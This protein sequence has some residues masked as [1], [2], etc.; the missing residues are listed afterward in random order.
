MRTNPWLTFCLAVAGLGAAVTPA[1]AQQ[2]LS[3]VLSVLLTNQAVPTG[4]FD[5][6]AAAAAAT[7]DTMERMLLVELTTLPLGSSSAGFSYRFNPTLGTLERATESFGPFFT[8]RALTAGSGRVALGATMQFARYT[9]L[10]GFDLRDGTF[11]TTG[12][13]F[14]DEAQPFD[15]EALTLRLTSRTI[16]LTANGGVTDRVDLG[17]AV[18]L[19]AISMDGTRV[20]TY[21]GTPVVQATA[22]ADAT[23]LGDIAVRGKFRLLG[24]GE[25]GLAAVGEVRL[26]TGR[27]EDLLGSGEMSIRGLFIASGVSGPVSLHA[28]FG[29]TGGGLADEVTWRGAIAAT[30]SPS[31]TV[32]GELVGRHIGEAGRISLERA[33]HPRLR[34]VDTL[35]LTT[36]GSSTTNVNL[37]AGVKWNAGS[38]VLLN[39]NVILP[40]TDNGLQ[41]TATALVGLEYAFGR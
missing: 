24:D 17:V 3:E 32:I 34:G 2:P 18:P 23:G 36:T 9:T 30:A 39:A 41:S 12:N 35:R 13:Q 11:V 38:T 19:V 25:A 37:V 5:K 16:T 27:E 20:N 4:D 31:V 21:R 26:P 29:L 10:D 40:L 15:V 14:V 6:D 8:E 33:P 7:R 1:H 22:E 28:N